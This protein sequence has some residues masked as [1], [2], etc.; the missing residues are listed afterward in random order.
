MAFV[1]PTLSQIQTRV[2]NDITSRAEL[3]TPLARATVRAISWAIAGTSHMLYG[4][5]NWISRQVMPDTA[6]QEN[7]ER[8]CSIWG[9]TRIEASYA[10]REVTLTGTVNGTVIPEGTVLVRSDGLEYTTDAEATIASLTAT[11][12]ITAS[13]AGT[14]YNSDTGTVLSFQSPIEFISTQAP[15]A[16]TNQVDAVDDETDAALL[17]RLLSRLQ[18]PPAGGTANDYVTWAKEVAGVTRAWCYPLRTGPGTVGVSFVRDNDA[19]L[20]PSAGEVAEVQ[21]YIDTKSPVTA[22]VTVFAPVEE[23]VDFEIDIAPNNTEVQDAIQAEIEDLFSRE[24]EPEGTLL[25]SHIREAISIAAGETDHELVS[26]TANITA[27][28]GVIKTVGTFTWGA[29]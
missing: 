10:E 12:A 9:V 16:A 27:G 3:G 23:T 11:V 7:L 19:S 15:I 18:Q 4:F 1:R 6:E 29:V 5:L 8:W 26:P 22:D 25:I 14:D 2:L 20:I 28:T 21:A 24:S 13:G 17:A